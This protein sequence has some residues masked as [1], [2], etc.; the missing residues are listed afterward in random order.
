L[1]ADFAGS[2]RAARTWD[3][4]GALNEVVLSKPSSDTA[5]KASI[6]ARDAVSKPVVGLP[7]GLHV[8]GMWAAASRLG[9][10]GTVQPTRLITTT[11]TEATVVHDGGEDMIL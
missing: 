1:S 10:G 6:P 4:C 3:R 7:G 5:L 2:S 8:R 9:F 11:A